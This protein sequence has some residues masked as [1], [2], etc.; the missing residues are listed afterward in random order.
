[1]ATDKDIPKKKKKAKISKKKKALLERFKDLE[2][3]MTSHP[4]QAPTGGK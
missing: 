3:L 1:M 4:I 2:D